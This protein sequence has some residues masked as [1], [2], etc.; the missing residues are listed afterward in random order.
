MYPGAL[1]WLSNHL[2]LIK[3]FPY[4]FTD[5]NWL[6]TLSTTIIKCLHAPQ[7]RESDLTPLKFFNNGPEWF[8]WCLSLPLYVLLCPDST[9]SLRYFLFSLMPLKESQKRLRVASHTKFYTNDFATFRKLSN[10]KI[11]AFFT[12]GN[13]ERM[14]FH[15]LCYIVFAMG[16]LKAY[17]TYNQI[18]IWFEERNILITSCTRPRVAVAYCGSMQ[19]RKDKLHFSND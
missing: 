9:Q 15:S 18:F 6:H 7:F 10:L 3:W 16:D 17:K 14:Y 12:Y 13:N 11:S 8:Y 2:A 4:I 19:K 1:I 5:V